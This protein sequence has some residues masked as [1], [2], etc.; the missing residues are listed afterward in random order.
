ML[1]K[2][3]PKIAEKIVPPNVAKKNFLKSM[4]LET[5]ACC[6]PFTP[7]KTIIKLNTRIIGIKEMSL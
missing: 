1:A 7:D 6:I 3:I 5:Y 2:H 4:C